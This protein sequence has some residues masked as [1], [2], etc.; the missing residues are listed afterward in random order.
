MIDTN[1]KTKQ[2]FAKLLKLYE[3]YSRIRNERNGDD[4]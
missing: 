3:K 2:I 1:K 4:V